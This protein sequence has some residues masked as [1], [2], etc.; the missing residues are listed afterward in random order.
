MFF[1]LFGNFHHAP[2]RSEPARQSG[3]SEQNGS[4]FV[5][6]FVFQSQEGEQ[7]NSYTTDEGGT[8]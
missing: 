3:Q 1:S 7:S 5:S 4:T 6:V 2:A 8:A